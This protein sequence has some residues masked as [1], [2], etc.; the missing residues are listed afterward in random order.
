LDGVAQAIHA[1]IV[2]RDSKNQKRP[3]ERAL[4][5]KS[6]SY[7]YGLKLVVQAYIE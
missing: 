5:S 3:A 7:F 4:N 2:K 6:A 1:T